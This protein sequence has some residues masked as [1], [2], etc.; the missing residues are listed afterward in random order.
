[1]SDSTWFVLRAQP[2]GGPSASGSP[3]IILG[4]KTPDP[5]FSNNYDA[6]FNATGSFGA[7]NY[8]Y[9]RA[10]NAA[11]TQ[12]IGTVSVYAAR[13]DNV[14]NQSTWVTLKTQ[15]GR[16]ATNIAAD[17][18]SV[19]VNGA[20]LVWT[21]GA[22]PPPSAPWVLIA[23]I[24]DDNHAPLQLPGTVKDL[25][26]FNKWIAQQSR[27]TAMTVQLPHVTP[28]AV[29]TF[30]WNRMIDLENS[31]ETGL[32]VSVSCTSGAAGGTLAYQFDKNDS[33][34]QPIGVGATAYQ[35]NAI[36]SQTR[37]IPPN[38]ASTLTLTFTPAADETASAQF[39]VQVSTQAADAGDEDLGDSPAP[40][41]FLN[42]NVSFS[43][44]R[45]KP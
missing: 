7:T 36:Y 2:A 33:Q 21:P 24:V 34:N 11:S 45:G 30:S 44:T 38:F 9:V 43:Q 25:A 18:Q 41:V 26:S 20:A 19:G 35:V 12:S 4:G 23:E 37:T 15:D 8:V 31:A 6:S 29:P 16:T 40:T 42:D 17:P 22:A 3:D 13:Q 5:K 39:S 27:V 10:K 32:L 1:M 14:Q 28:V